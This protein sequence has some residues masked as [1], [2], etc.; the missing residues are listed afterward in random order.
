MV[1]P[2]F[3]LLRVTA[4]GVSVQVWLWAAVVVVGTAVSLWAYGSFSS[5]A[6]I[7]LSLAGAGVLVAGLIPPFGHTYD[8]MLA[9]AAGLAWWRGVA[10]AQYGQ[11]PGAASEAILRLAGVSAV[12]LLLQLIVRVPGWSDAAAPYYLV[13]FVAGLGT[14]AAARA[15]SLRRRRASAVH[16]D[17][18]WSASGSLAAVADAALLLVPALLTWALARLHLPSLGRLASLLGRWTATLLVWMAVAVFFVLQWPVMALTAVLRRLAGSPTRGAPGAD[19]TPLRFPSAQPHQWP[20]E[21]LEFVGVV[22]LV[23]LSV[24]LG[25]FIYRAVHRLYWADSSDDA[26]PEDRESVFEWKKM[27]R[28]HLRGRGRL[29][30]ADELGSGPVARVRRLYRRLQVAGEGA[31]RRRA[32]SET[33]AEYMRALEQSSLSMEVVQCITALYQ[34]V[35]YGDIMPDDTAVKVAERAAADGLPGRV[36]SQPNRR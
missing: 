7:R 35:R 30:G 33:P 1:Y 8:P 29:A 10:A 19:S 11:N 20:A 15:E 14:L 34:D 13:M 32:L 12:P 31:G 4:G 2:F 26:V 6:S 3:L 21:W 25:W 9:L 27:W 5:L 23:L 18:H 24:L 28:Q 36:T 16:A 22:A 17:R